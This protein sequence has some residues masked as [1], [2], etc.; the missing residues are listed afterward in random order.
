MPVLTLLITLLI[1]LPMVDCTTRSMQL[2]QRA[3]LLGRP[4]S[5][6]DTGEA[7]FQ[8]AGSLEWS[9][10]DGGEN[11][12][13]R[14]ATAGDN[15]LSYFEVVQATSLPD[16]KDLCT[17]R[18]DCKGVEYHVTG[19]CEIWTRM[20]GIG[21]S[22]G[23]A[24]YSCWRYAMSDFL[25]IRG[26][27]NRFCRGDGPTDSNS[28]YYDVYAPISLD[29]CKE[30]CRRQASCQGVEYSEEGRCEVWS[31]EIRATQ[32]GLG[33]SCLRLEF[34]NVDGSNDR[35][36]R[37][38]HAADNPPEYYILIEGAS[39]E[40]CKQNC[41]LNP[42]CV[43]IEHSGSRCEVWTR[44]AGIEASVPLVGTTCL[45]YN[46]LESPTI[47]QNAQFLIQA[48]FGPTPASLEE[49]SMTT[50]IKWIDD[51]MSLPVESHRE[52]YRRQV[53]PRTLSK[54]FEKVS[55][56]TRSRC[57]PGS[58]WVGYAL[59]TSDESSSIKVSQNQLFVNGLLRTDIDP[60]YV[61]NQ[62][63]APQSCT[64]IPPSHWDSSD[65]CI[66]QA[67]SWNCEDEVWI[68]ETLCQQTCF[69]KGKGYE[70]N[71]CSSGWVGLEYE[72]FVCKVG[73]DAV[74]AWVQLSSDSSCLTS[75]RAML[76][77]QVWKAS[78]T[79]NMVQS[80]DLGIFRPG[81]LHLLNSPAQCNLGSI[82]RSDVESPGLFYLLENRLEL[83]ENNLDK[84]ASSVAWV[85]GQC[86]NVPKTFINEKSCQLLPGCLPT[87]IQRV[88]VQLDKHNLEKFFTIGGRYVYA[89]TQ[90]RPGISPCGFPSRW[91]Q[92][93]CTLASCFQSSLV[94]TDLAAIR[95]QLVAAAAQGPLRD[96]QVACQQV[97]AGS[98]V[99]VDT[100]FFQH[101]HKDELNVYD[102]TD[103]VESHPGGPDAISRWAS[104]DFKLKFPSSHS[105]DR[106]FSG[107]V[108]GVI[109]PGFVGKYGDIVD[110][111]RLPQNLQSSALSKAFTAVAAEVQQSMVCGSPG[112]VANNPSRGHQLSLLHGGDYDWRFDAGYHNSRWDID[113]LS[114]STVWTMKALSAQDQLRQR[115]AWALSQTF[116]AA[117]QNH[118]FDEM[119]EMWLN[120]Y[121]IFVR[122]AFGNFRD[123]LREVTYSPIMGGYLTYKRNRAFDSGGTYP[124]ENY[125]REIMQ[126]FTIGLWRLNPDGS[127]ML[128]ARNQYIPTYGNDHIMNF[129][130]VFTGFDEQPDRGNMEYVH[131]RNFIDPMRI[132]VSWHDVY[133]K[134]DLNGD[135]LGDGYP[136]CS[137]LPAGSF[138]R[139]GATYSF[140]GHIVEDK[141]VLHLSSD[142]AL[143]AVLCAASTAG[144]PCSFQVKLELS[145]DLKCSSSAECAVN[146]VRVVKVGNG[147][148]E[149]IPP[150]CVNLFFFN[151]QIT[152][153][154]G[155]AW[156][157]T[158]KCQDP[159]R[160]VAGTACC[161]G[162]KNTKD[163]WWLD[164]KACSCENASQ[165]CPEMFTE[166]CHTDETWS[167]NKFCQLACW[168]GDA[169]YAGDDCS[170]GPWHAERICGYAAER[171]NFAEAEQKCTQRGL[172]VCAEKLEGFG[173]DYDDMPVWTPEACSYELIVHPG[174]LVSS[175]FSSKSLQNKFS[176]QWQNGFPAVV[177]G[178]CPGGCQVT[179]DSCTCQLRVETRPV[180][181]RIPTK[182]EVRSRLRIGS[183]RPSTAC[184]LNC[185]GDV[186]TYMNS[187]LDASTVFEVDGTFFKNKEVLVVVGNHAFRNPPVFMKS[188]QPTE[189][190]AQAE[191]ESLL[192]HLFKH[193]NAP[194]FFA[195][196]LIQRIVTS[197]PTSTYVQA[198][199]EAFKTGQYNS[200]TYGGIYGDLAAS[201]AAVLLHPEAR[202]Q[203]SPVNGLLR[204]PLV[205]VI[206][207]M[208]SMEY[209]D[210]AGRNVIM[211]NLMGS[212]GQW[213][214]HAPSVFNFYLPEFK[215][216]AFAESLVGPEFQIFTPPAAISFMNGMFSLIEHGLGQCDAGFGY[217]AE[218]CSNGRFHLGELECVQPTLDRMNL[219][220]T[221]GRLNSTE[222]IKQAYLA[223]DGGDQYKAAQMAVVMTPEF[224]TQG[225]PLPQELRPERKATAPPLAPR[226]YKALIMLMMQGGADT[227]NM[228][229]PW[230][231]PL[232][233]EYVAIRKSVALLPD[234]LQVISTAGQAC[235]N[236]GIHFQLPVVKN[237]YDQGEAAFVSNIGSLVEPLTKEQYESG[238]RMYCNG[239]FSHSDQQLAAQT[240]KCQAATTSKGVGGRLADALAAG[241][242][243]L[244]T[245]SYSVAG[246]SRWSQ[247]RETSAE[248]IDQHSG[249]VRF[250]K[251]K[252]VQDVIDNITR[253]KHG[254]IYC[255][256]FS[257]RLMHAVD[258]N[259]KLRQQLQGAKLRTAYA[260]QD[261]ELS[262]Q[263]QQVA[264]LIAAHERRGAE[265]D[266]F[267]VSQGGFDTHARMLGDLDDK[268]AQM[269]DALK[270]FVAEMKAQGV[271]D[272]IVLVT[273]SDFGRTLTA[274]T[275]HGTDHGWSGNHIIIGGGING[276]RIYND[277]VST[278]HEGGE[279]DAGR[280][281]II[282]AYPWES[283]MVPV[284]EWMGLDASMHMDVF[285][286]LGNFNSTHIISRS[287]LF[288]S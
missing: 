251:Y 101:V 111:H 35:A 1:G 62:M 25:P 21:A 85:G 177:A 211:E 32:P 3:N 186:R 286:N 54:D 220:L 165:V 26:G 182:E 20:D 97:P 133:P 249:S 276:G 56:L 143:Y 272:S 261:S 168:K 159:H 254:N 68:E 69:N 113:R 134:P 23:L 8:D 94:E 103:F 136:L 11:R 223:A 86:P 193:P 181:T 203:D 83:V 116:V 256:E 140:L 285:P 55:G 160:Q 72:G 107:G 93:D 100:N 126:L 227:F 283:I 172:G 266:L 188:D 112:E 250:H 242:Q 213:P 205:K 194:P 34:T 51:Q 273:H 201:V 27:V 243:S 284:A 236:F 241:S 171:V 155:R 248:I 208:R 262:K 67:E 38:A 50:Y 119:S 90:L 6:V 224:H 185:A 215:P 144:V 117:V 264:R 109:L 151:G 149:Y 239:L 202:Y 15:S 189:G 240:L 115:I 141:D 110:L 156:G 217:H 150:T 259:D 49:L 16:C 102:F 79:S 78:P 267:Y 191:V 206:H 118:V 212:I 48:T 61:G 29:H 234:Q 76:N 124:D 31:H 132:R 104:M 142:S 33:F 70:G 145:G 106:W 66:H 196:R 244:R 99:Q 184:N 92:M 139:K 277:F 137:E 260:V 2:I 44:A 73:G 178:A 183:V 40:A 190:D 153:E 46:A 287:A 161:A 166:R 204:E 154:G 135:F 199:G 52:Y 216:E 207:F 9:P 164:W 280:G 88:Q 57:K 169:P 228:L 278:F 84:P 288:K 226:S 180:F 274:N 252:Q 158:K 45:K 4:V 187:V 39:L 130:R 42:K 173:C 91:H 282:P 19:R 221:G 167:K 197:N 47:E 174:G 82:V 89:V 37:G 218:R 80:L 131:N 237:L 238:S 255:E 235:T 121:D 65:A 123:V 279:Q 128:D 75:F 263:L 253:I 43:G 195:Y 74:G 24:G 257:G 28:S 122:N 22:I 231:C 230:A 232:Y 138:L 246:I 192:D 18:S 77:V 10:V 271:F 152:R 214:H 258:S 200:K 275:E 64:D 81:V 108:P 127:R 7:S 13:C 245:T 14:G 60:A 63:A 268:F 129:A 148:Y 270:S 269:N 162:C 281:R 58:R 176:V 17:K 59:R 179:G 96:I 41:R 125:A 36:C 219:L 120:Y 198:V 222:V 157:W 87:G 71:D 225:N 163:W 175:N 30:L 209:A 229:V 5:L 12:A 233:D 53:S 210:H 147:Y 98:V 105:M 146:T 247:G 170:Y 114:K 265:R 95:Q